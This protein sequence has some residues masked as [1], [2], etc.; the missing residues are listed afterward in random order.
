MEADGQGKEGGRSGGVEVQTGDLR[1][2][3]EDTR[4]ESMKGFE[5]YDN[6]STH[7]SHFFD[8]DGA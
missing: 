1:Q 3:G 8:G 5:V 7:N 6:D 4:E 2:T